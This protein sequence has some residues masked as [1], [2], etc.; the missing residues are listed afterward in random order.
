MGIFVNVKSPG[1]FMGKTIPVGGSGPVQTNP[2]DRGDQQRKNADVQNSPTFDGIRR[3][4]SACHAKGRD[5][6]FM[7]KKFLGP[8]PKCKMMLNVFDV[9]TAKFAVFKDARLQL[10]E[11]FRGEPFLDRRFTQG[12]E[13]RRACIVDCFFHGK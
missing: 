10:Y 1:D 4:T 5:A 7:G 6:I 8:F 12:M 3:Q 9:I 13:F 2:D 11:L